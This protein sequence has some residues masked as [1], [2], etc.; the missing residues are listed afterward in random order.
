MLDLN[1]INPSDP[2]T[3]KA[4]SV[5][6]DRI[7]RDDRVRDA[8]T[9]ALRIT[10]RFGG[11]PPG[12]VV[13]EIFTLRLVALP[14]Y[15][16][17]EITALFSEH[18]AGA[19]MSRVDLSKKIQDKIIS[20]PLPKREAF[21]QELLGVFEAGAKHLTPAERAKF[22][23]ITTML[24]AAAD[25]SSGLDERILVRDAT[26]AFRELKAGQFT[27]PPSGASP[28]QPV[29]P[30][31]PVSAPTRTPVAPAPPTGVPVARRASF[32]FHPEDEEEAKHFG[33]SIAG[34]PQVMLHSR[35]AAKDI[36]GAL[37]L[38]FADE[39]LEKRFFA[40]CAARLKDVRD[41]L[42]TEEQLTRSPK[43]GGLGLPADQAHR[44]VE[45]LEAARTTIESTGRPNAVPTRPV[46]V[47]PRSAPSRSPAV[48]AAK[49]VPAVTPA[50]PPVSKPVVPVVPV[51][52]PPASA[53]LTQPSVPP[54]APPKIVAPVP[55][56]PKPIP[57]PKS[58][59]VPT[60]NRP[61]APARVPDVVDIKQPARTM[62]PVDELGSL[63]LIDFRRLGANLRQRE[64]KLIEKVKLLEEQSFVQ[65]YRGLE[66]WKR[67]PVWQLYS[68]IGSEGLASGKS[69]DSIIAERTGRGGETLTLEEF[70]MMTDLNRRMRE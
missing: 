25:E 37:G 33:A 45:R 41:G 67:S 56:R 12:E 68:S 61:I 11:T 34:E 29:A 27:A 4:I 70:N 36:I 66:A 31:R 55:L 13:S 5:E 51:V 58:F 64:E 65:K 53:P 20:L 17:Q 16:E 8:K 28:P 2:K 44:V 43:I 39:V 21:K 23:E 59:N 9:L 40:M 14:L 52:P 49:P 50:P 30:S 42:E 10:E 38:S 57:P 69:V 48:V 6:V 54:P 18:L 32:F 19:L 60:V 15:P 63:T 46:S 7:V 62:G 26:G 3:F 47:V 22:G 24:A 1:T 35:Q